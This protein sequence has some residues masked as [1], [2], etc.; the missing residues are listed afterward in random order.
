MYSI[1]PEVTRKPSM[2]RY[3]T[4]CQMF[5]DRKHTTRGIKTSCISNHNPWDI[6]LYIHIKIVEKKP[7]IPALISHGYSAH[8]ISSIVC[9]IYSQIQTIKSDHPAAH[10]DILIIGTDPHIVVCLKN[11]LSLSIYIY[12]HYYYTCACMVQLERKKFRHRL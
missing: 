10:A 5:G 3:V 4:Q 12:I 1:S 9:N 2:A 8:H 7:S 6:D 11:I